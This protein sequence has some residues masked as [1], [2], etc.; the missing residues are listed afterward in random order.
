MVKDDVNF[1][2]ARVIAKERGIK[3]SEATSTQSE[4]YVNLITVR[5]ITTDMTSTVAGTIFGKS[6]SR[7]VRINTSR[8]KWCRRGIWP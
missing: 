1:V 5:I 2:N 7:V 8:W 4:D 3:V 6:D